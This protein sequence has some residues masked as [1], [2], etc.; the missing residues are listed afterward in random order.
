MTVKN[1]RVNYKVLLVNFLKNILFLT[2]KILFRERGREGEREGEEHQYV[3]ASHVSPTGDLARNPSMCPDREP[4]P[5]PFGSQASTQST[6][7][8]Q[9]GLGDCFSFK[10]IDTFMKSLMTLMS[11]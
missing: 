11:Q 5:Q 1:K 9:P 6:E 3:V 2:E 7:P 10:T 4:N 8:H